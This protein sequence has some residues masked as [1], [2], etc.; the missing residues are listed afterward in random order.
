MK[1]EYVAPF[2]EAATFVFKTL[3]GMAPERGQLSARPQ[4]STTHQINVVCGIE[5]PVEGLVIIGMK[6][7]TADKLAARM[8]GAPVV[9][10]DAAAANAIADLGT[11]IVSNAATLISESGYGVGIRPPAIIRGANVKIAT[12]ELPSLV[13]PLH[14]KNFGTLEISVSLQ[15]RPPIAMAA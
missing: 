7:V 9:T 5:G 13:I 10:F 1:V 6:T 3:L 2:A 8:I 15:E 14:L 11:M 12:L 4:L